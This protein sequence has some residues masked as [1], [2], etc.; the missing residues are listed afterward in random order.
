MSFC[1]IYDFEGPYPLARLPAPEVDFFLRPGD[2]D[3]VVE[4]LDEVLDLTRM[5]RVGQKLF[6]AKL[7]R[8]LM[9]TEIVCMF[10]H[11]SFGFFS[12]TLSLIRVV[13]SWVG[14]RIFVVALFFIA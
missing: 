10:S 12:I 2:I 8:L 11:R 6:H 1:N 5:P 13:F 3:L 7:E 14:I 9:E 4:I